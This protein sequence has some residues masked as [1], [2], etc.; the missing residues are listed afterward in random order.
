MEMLIAQL[1][2]RFGGLYVL[3]ITT[4]REEEAEVMALAHCLTPNAKKVYGLS[5]T[6][7]FE[8]P[9]VEVKVADVFIAV[10]QAKKYLH[11]HAWGLSDTTL[12]DVFVKIA[13]QSNSRATLS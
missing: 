12:E 4:P 13:R 10:E 7:K 6:Q 2:A 1:I 9:K 5:G 3:T 11:I 8:L